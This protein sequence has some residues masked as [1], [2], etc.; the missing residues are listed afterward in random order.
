MQAAILPRCDQPFSI[1][2]SWKRE[3]IDGKFVMKMKMKMKKSSELGEKLNGLHTKMS[4]VSA[5]IVIMFAW[6][7]AP[8]SANAQLPPI[9]S[10]PGW[11]QVPQ[12]A[13]A[14]AVGKSCADLAPGMIRNALGATPLKQNALAL[15]AILSSRNGAISSNTSP[16]TWA[17]EAFRR[18]GAD[19]VY[20][21]KFGESA[22]F[23]NVV[24]E[25]RGRDKPQDYV[26]FGAVLDGSSANQLLTAEGAAILI[27]AVRVVHNTG[28][29]PR[30]SIRFVLF[31]AGDENDQ[32][33]AA[34]AW[35][36]VRAHRADLDRVAAAVSLGQ[37]DGALDGFSLEARPDAL[38]A[39]KQALGPL[40]PLGIRN[41]TQQVEIPTIVT[42]FWLEGLPTL[43]A[44]APS[45]APTAQKPDSGTLSAQLA[46]S[47]ATLRDLKRRVAV[48]A[49]AAYALAD[50]EARVGPPISRAQV[51]KSIKS[52][53]LQP[54]LS[55]SGQSA[56]WQAAESI[57]SH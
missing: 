53:Q 5:C 30:R 48:A 56:E 7:A 39:V 50:A 37:R 45:A 44:D 8:R 42:P 22:Q 17:V 38:G 29:I 32:W 47:P 46:I 6:F 28:N 27:D 49:V 34:G 51:E 1:S 13:G 4:M 25:I 57:E 33:R 15:A 24:A 9:E 36:Y 2:V 10:P 55:R 54:K 41:F 18:A 35:A 23:E 11:G 31:A 26:L 43:V 19:E 12:G 40:R 52:M 14:C 3:R 21:E 16:A 20:L